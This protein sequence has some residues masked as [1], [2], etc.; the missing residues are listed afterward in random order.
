MA[1]MFVGGSMNLLWTAGLALFMLI[2]KV[3][4]AGRTVGQIAGAGL[5][6]WGV[7]LLGTTLLGVS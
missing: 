3:L 7:S 1:L 2:E 5:V 6:V 4:P